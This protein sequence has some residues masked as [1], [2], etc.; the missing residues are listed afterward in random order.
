LIGS[1]SKI[2]AEIHRFRAIFHSNS[3][4]S[5]LFP[6]K[7]SLLPPFSAHLPSIQGN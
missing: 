3:L 6:F 7:P 1:Q 5:F 2:L 4:I